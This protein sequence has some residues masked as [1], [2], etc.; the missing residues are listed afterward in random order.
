[1]ITQPSKSDTVLIYL[2]IVAAVLLMVSRGVM[3]VLSNSSAL[4]QHPLLG[5]ANIFCG[6]LLAAATAQSSL[7]KEKSR[8]GLSLGLQLCIALNLLALALGAAIAEHVLIVLML[9]YSLFA[10]HRLH[11]DS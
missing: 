1:M 5:M 4:G 6:V 7:T 10:I 8:R 11:P 3:T 9:A 2:G